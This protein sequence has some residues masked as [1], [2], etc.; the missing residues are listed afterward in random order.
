MSCTIRA[1]TLISPLAMGYAAHQQP[2]LAG[3]CGLTSRR[4]LVA[5]EQVAVGAL[6]AEPEPLHDALAAWDS[7]SNR[8]LAALLAP[9]SEPLQGAI[10]R[11]GAARVGVVIGCTTSGIAD[12]EP[13][14]GAFERDAAWPA[15]FRYD[16]QELGDPARF[17]A[18]VSG[19]AGPSYVVST[20][21]TSGAKAM[22]SAALLLEAGLC[23]AVLCGGIDTLCGLTLNGFA[24]LEAVSP[25]PCLPFSRNRSG[26]SIGEGGALF[27]LDRE[28]GALRLAGWGE[29]CDAYHLSAPDPEGVGAELAIRAALDAVGLAPGEIG[30]IN[31]HGTGTALNDQVEAQVTHRLFGDAACG[32]TKGMT[33]HMLGAAGACEA[34]FVAIALQRGIL[35]PHLWDGVADPELPPIGLVPQAGQR[36]ASRYMMS[37]SYAFGGNNCALVLARE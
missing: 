37:C 16:R 30:Y 15:S 26:I 29:S 8:L 18:H 28:P 20:A 21:C 7:R 3:R 12:S 17:A 5:G 32:S 34:A 35:P 11:W 19:A 22:V 24:A 14:Y 9:L 13:A 36:C 6:P 31:L 4:T 25:G 10:A 23:D 2:L 27:L 33:G 1:I